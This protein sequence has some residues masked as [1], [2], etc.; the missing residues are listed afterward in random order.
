MRND[1]WDV[2]HNLLSRFFQFIMLQAAAISLHTSRYFCYFC[3]SIYSFFFSLF[4]SLKI[5]KSFKL[6]IF[7]VYN[8]F[9]FLF[10]AN[11]HLVN[12][13]DILAKKLFICICNDQYI[14]FC[15]WCCCEREREESWNG[16]SKK[17][18]RR[19][20]CLTLTTSYTYC[21]FIHPRINSTH[22][23]ELFRTQMTKR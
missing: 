21:K 22:S 3:N 6:S 16:T 15:C 17:G 19:C 7:H 20:L 12:L 1:H 13:F 14:L 2:C 11:Y 23:R 10:I 18:E 5:I 8:F 9:F 4:I